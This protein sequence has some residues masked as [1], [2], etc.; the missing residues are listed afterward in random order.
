MD[1]GS[2]VPLLS[3]PAKASPAHKLPGTKG[4][5]NSLRE[6]PCAWRYGG[7]EETLDHTV[8]LSAWVLMGG[9]VGG[10]VGVGVRGRPTQLFQERQWSAATPP[11]PVP[12]PY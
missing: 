7:G 1:T 6:L 2:P 11:T 10:W 4:I 3:L 5:P 8:A 12:L 9:G